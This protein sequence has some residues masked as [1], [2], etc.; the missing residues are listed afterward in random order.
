MTLITITTI[1]DLSGSGIKHSTKKPEKQR[2]EGVPNDDSN[3]F[4]ILLYDATKDTEGKLLG[5]TGAGKSTTSHFLAGSHLKRHRNTGH[6]YPA[7]VRKQ[8]ITSV[9]VNM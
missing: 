8:K 6:K 2:Q 4:I 7:N 5:H 3:I 1:I 9:M